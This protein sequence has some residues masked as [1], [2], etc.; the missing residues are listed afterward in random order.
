MCLNSGGRQQP[1]PCIP[2]MDN[3]KRQWLY[4]LGARRT[5]LA[6]DQE[7]VG[8]DLTT[9]RPTI[10]MF[11]LRNLADNRAAHT[12]VHLVMERRGDTDQHAAPYAARRYEIDFGYESIARP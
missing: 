8:V 10:R 5:R 6:A 1:F 9:P 7:T 3:S 12:I 2:V 11:P 4:S